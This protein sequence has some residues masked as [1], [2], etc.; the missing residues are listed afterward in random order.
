A[1]QALRLL[2][3]L[4]LTPVRPAWFGTAEPIDRATVRAAMARITAWNQHLTARA[5]DRLDAIDGIT[6]Y[7]PR[8][9]ARRTSLVSFNFPGRDPM[10][11]ADALN[12]VGGESRAGWRGATPPH[13][14]LR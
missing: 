11:V 4:A 1:G 13:R 6:I 12:Q 9:P 10:P 7:G 3:D 14:R 8:D 5:L 2:L